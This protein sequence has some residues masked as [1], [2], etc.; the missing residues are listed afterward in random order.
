MAFPE[1]SEYETLI[2]GLPGQFPEI[3]ASMLH[4]YSTSA[5]TGTLEGEIL[6]KNG[7]RIQVVEVLDFGSGRIRKYSYTIYKGEQKIR[8][9]DP[10]PHSGNPELAATFPHHY[11]EEPAPSTSSGQSIKHNRK[12]APGISFDALNM[13]ALIETCLRLGKE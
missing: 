5:S 4:L 6:L 11:H 9:Y 8:W 12:P 10:Q 7:L 13:P 1:R 3:A 2:Y